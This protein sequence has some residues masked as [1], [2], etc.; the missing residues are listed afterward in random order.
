MPD[1]MVVPVLRQLI[2]DRYAVSTGAAHAFMCINLIGAL[3][4]VGMVNRLRRRRRPGTIIAIAALFNGLLLATMALPIGFF[5]TLAVR[6][7][8]GAADLTVYAILFDLIARTGSANTKGRRMG[9]AATSLMLGIA[10]GLGL[11]GL[12]GRIH[13]EFSLWL[14][15]IACLIVAPT[16]LLLLTGSVIKPD[17]N[18]AA[19]TTP[20]AASTAPIWPALV[21]MFSDRAVV[22]VLVSTVPLYLASIARFS[23]TAIGVLIGISM[24]MTALGAWPTGRLAERIGV[25]RLRLFAGLIFAFCFPAIIVMALQSLIMVGMVLIGFGLAGAALFASSLLVVCNSGRGPAGMAAYHAAGNFGF[26]MGPA[27]AG[28]VLKLFGGFEPGIGVYVFILSACATMHL[29]ATAVTFI[30]MSSVWRTSSLAPDTSQDLS[31]ELAR[32]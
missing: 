6:F 15:A 16:A 13:P 11:G 7:V 28:T 27:F 20:P 31:P 3:T 18:I 4:V 29:I 26:L 30:G 21:M 10:V 32:P 12:A 24:L 17:K 14:G 25:L 2:V 1:A 23:S 8:E 19:P 5:P 22:G 9:A